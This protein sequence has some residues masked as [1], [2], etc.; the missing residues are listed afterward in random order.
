MDKDL[1]AKAQG[2]HKGA[3]EHL[4]TPHL[5][6]LLAYCRAICGD[7]H[8]A[9]D[10]VQQT[11]LIAYRKLN[12]FFPEADFA[13][14]L[15]AI[16]RREALVARRSLAKSSPLPGEE[17]LEC[18]FNDPTPTAVAPDR[19]ALVKCLESLQ[20]RDDRSAR[21]VRAHYFDGAQVAGIAGELRLNLN[22]VKTL[23]YRAR[24][25]LL[26]CVERRLKGA[27]AP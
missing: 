13:A 14:W 5:P 27:T 22:T 10:A 7:Y 23:L 20:E 21:I 12:L 9:Q 26:E 2:G 19:E 1:I 18:A 3:F 11:A 8:V 16:A 17:I 25:A 15:K 24:L 6:M 4:L